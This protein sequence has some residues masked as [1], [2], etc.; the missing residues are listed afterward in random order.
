MKAR[1]SAAVAVLLF[2]LAS[3]VIVAQ[4]GRASGTA[5][6]GIYYGNQGW[7][8]DQVGHLETWQGKKHAVVNLFTNWCNRSTTINNLFG[9]QLVNIWNNRALTT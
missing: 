5:L 1:R 6:L 7:K 9:Q 8:M 2:C 4:P 3:L